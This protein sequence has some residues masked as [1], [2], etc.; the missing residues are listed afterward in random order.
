MKE[1]VKYT[2]ASQDQIN[3]GG[4]DDPRNLL[5]VGNIYTVLKREVHS[6]HTKVYLEE[7][8]DMKFNSVSFE[9]ITSNPD[10]KE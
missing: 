4:N 5:T 9:E 3:W 2:G 8:P 1:E 10:R 6:W 7:F